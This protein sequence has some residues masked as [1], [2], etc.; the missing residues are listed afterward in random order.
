LTAAPELRYPWFWRM[1]GWALVVG[2]AVGSLM[3][4]NYIAGVPASDKGMHA[5]A[6]FTLMLWFAGQ[7]ARERHWILAVLIFSLGF[8]LDLAQGLIPTRRFDLAD[9]A[10]NAG[11]ILAAFALSWFLLAGWCRRVEEFFVS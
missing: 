5:L 6:Y 8:A 4:A 2:V 1:L 3:P 11:G 7:Y 9:V 10:V